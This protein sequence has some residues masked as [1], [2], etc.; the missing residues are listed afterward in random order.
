MVDMK[1]SKA[2]AKEQCT[3][4]D[5]DLNDFQPVK[6]WLGDALHQ[7]YEELG[8]F[9]TASSIILP[10]RAP[11]HDEPIQ[12]LPGIGDDVNLGDE[13]AITAKATVTS[14]SGYQTMMGDSEMSLSLQI[15]DMEVSGGSSKSAKALYDKS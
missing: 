9:G 8:A 4:S 3:P 7:M 2:E 14:K 5:P 10:E 1:M 12:R 15:T 11:G 13:V 6:L